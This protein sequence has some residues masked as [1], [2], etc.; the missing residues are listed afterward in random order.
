[1]IEGIVFRV[2]DRYRLARPPEGFG[3]WQ[4]VWK[5][6]RRL[7]VDGT[8]AKLVTKLFDDADAAGEIDWSVSIDSRSTALTST[9]QPFRGTHG[10]PSTFTNP[11]LQPADQALRR[12]REGLSTIRSP[13]L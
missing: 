13:R 6:H 10:A 12:L 3:P 5:R 9:P 2:P 1:V 8:W 11:L 7:S 4:T